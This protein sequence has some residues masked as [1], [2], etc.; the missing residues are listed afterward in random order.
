MA[1]SPIAMPQNFDAWDVQDQISYLQKMKND[2][3][4]KKTAGNSQPW[5]DFQSLPLEYRLM[6]NRENYDN[7]GVFRLGSEQADRFVGTDRDDDLHGV[8][9][10][11]V[12]IG[13]A[14]NDRLFGGA[15]ND[16]LEGGAGNDVMFS[17]NNDDEIVDLEGVNVMFGGSGNDRIH[18]RGFLIGGAGNDT[19]IGS[20]EDDTY[21]FHRGDGSDTIEDPNGRDLLKFTD[22]IAESQLWM[23]K[24]DGG[25]NISVIGTSDN[26]FIK[27][28]FTDRAHAIEEIRVANGKI[29][30]AE[31]VNVLV[32]AMAKFSPPAAGQTSLPA[33]YAAAL[34]NVLAA[35][36]K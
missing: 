21:V 9:S 26:V 19:L 15:D 18:G 36:W 2:A 16:R 11:D 1:Y 5:N 13:G 33:Q 28:F 29:L 23:T 6:L 27:N 8:A 30:S 31:R 20:T 4:Q 14:G 32:E 12:L 7:F 22:N 34:Q 17:G 10:N 24:K 25:L 35:S 3:Y